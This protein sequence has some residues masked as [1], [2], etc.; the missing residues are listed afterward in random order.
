MFIRFAAI[1]TNEFRQTDLEN[2]GQSRTIYLW[3]D[4][5]DLLNELQQRTMNFSHCGVIAKV[6]KFANLTSNLKVKYVDD[7]DENW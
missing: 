3:F 4:G 2:E 6:V 5:L 1:I 7:L